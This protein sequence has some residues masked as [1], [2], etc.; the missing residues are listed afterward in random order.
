LATAVAYKQP[1]NLED[2]LIERLQ[3]HKEQ[4]LRAGI[5]TESEVQNVFNLFDLKKEGVISKERCI[6]GINNY[7][8]NYNSYTNNGQL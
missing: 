3:L 2:F 1:Q 4:G 6:K 5:F 8:H 7:I